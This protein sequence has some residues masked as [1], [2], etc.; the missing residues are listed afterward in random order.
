M[1]R[2]WGILLATVL[3]VKG[4]LQ[5]LCHMS[6]YGI[7]SI[8]LHTGIY[9]CVNL[10]AVLIDIVVSAVL[11][12]VLITPAI[13]R[14]LFPSD[15]VVD[16]LNF[17]PRLILRADRLCSGHISAKILT[18]IGSR[19]FLVVGTLEIELYRLLGVC[20][21]VGICDIAFLTHLREN[22]VTT[23]QTTILMTYRIEI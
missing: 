8:L 12:L 14:I 18:K 17:L 9:G 6:I 10:Q 22:H 13:E 4:W 2:E 11:V 21:I 5:I 20:L 23:L 7:L 1:G 16:E 19:A 3:L 15:R